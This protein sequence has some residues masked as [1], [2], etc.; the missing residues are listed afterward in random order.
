MAIKYIDAQGNFVAETDE[1]V[2]FTVNMN[3]PDA[4]NFIEGVKRGALGESDGVQVR[5]QGKKPVKRSTRR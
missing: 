2:A 3:D 1:K 5:V 4:L